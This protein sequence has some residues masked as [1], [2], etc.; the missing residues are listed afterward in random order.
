[1]AAIATLSFQ[2][3]KVES[4]HPSEFDQADELEGELSE[5]DR[6]ILSKLASGIH[7][8]R[9]TA[10]AIFFLESVK[11]LNLVGSSMMVF[12]RPIVTVIWNDPKRYDR[13]RQLL[14]HRGAMEL[15]VRRLEEQAST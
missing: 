2:F 9:L 11:P 15:L 3:S 5:D 10:P 12:F 8:R 13:V 4:M 7:R 1:M 6:E 14:E